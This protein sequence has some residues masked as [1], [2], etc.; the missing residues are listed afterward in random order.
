[1]FYVKLCQIQPLTSVDGKVPLI[2]IEGLIQKS[3]T[4]AAWFKMQIC[5][6]FLFGIVGSNLAGCMDVSPF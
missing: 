1:M 2:L 3:K 5:C 6:H 4:V